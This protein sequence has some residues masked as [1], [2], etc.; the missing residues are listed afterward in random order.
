M[1]AAKCLAAMTTLA[2]G[3]PVCAEVGVARPADCVLKVNTDTV[4][5]GPCD[6]TPLDVDGSFIIS[7]RDGQFFAYVTIVSRGVAEGHWNETPFATHAHTPLG[8]LIRNGACWSND[9]ASVC[10][11]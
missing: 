7:T 8:T 9:T 4:I 5:D 10:A 3:A 6:F 1:K 11:Y 2:F